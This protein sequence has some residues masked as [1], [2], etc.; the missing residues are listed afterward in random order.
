MRSSSRCCCSSSSLNGA[1]QLWPFLV[2]A[3]AAGCASAI[4][5][6]PGR[7]LPATLVPFELIASAMALRSIAFQ[8]AMIAGPALGGL[9]FT[10]SPELVYGAAAG[11]ARDRPRL[12]PR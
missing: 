1:T 9:L 11:A 5:M 6:P 3:F 12:R 10:I 4:A 2:L 8:A 7:A